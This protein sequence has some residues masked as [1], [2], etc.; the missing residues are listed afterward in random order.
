MDYR[1]WTHLEPLHEYLY[2]ANLLPDELH[3]ALILS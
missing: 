2:P 3:Q 1:I